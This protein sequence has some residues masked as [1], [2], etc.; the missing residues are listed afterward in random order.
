MLIDKATTTHKRFKI[1]ITIDDDS[2]CNIEHGSIQAKLILRAALLLVNE[3]NMLGGKSFKAMDRSLRDLTKIDAPFGG[4]TILVSG[5]WRQIL[6]VVKN[7]DHASMVN[8]TLKRTPMWTYMTKF[9][10]TANL[11]LQTCK[12]SSATLQRE[13]ADTFLDIGNGTAGPFVKL[14]DEICLPM[15]SNH[16]DLIQCIYGDIRNDPSKLTPE[17]LGKKALL[18]SLNDTVDDLNSEMVKM[19]PG[20]EQILTSTDD[21]IQDDEEGYT[22]P[23]EFIQTLTPKGL[24]PHELIL[25]QGTVVMVIRNLNEGA[26]I[27]NGTRMVVDKI[28]QFALKCTIITEGAF[29][30]TKVH[31]PRIKFNVTEDSTFDFKF[32]RIQFPVRIAFAMTIHKSEGQTLETVGLYLPEPVYGHGMLYTALTRAT[33]RKGIKVLLGTNQKPPDSPDGFYTANVVYRNVLM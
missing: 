22:V 19:L 9:K 2:F 7:G 16:H 26:G 30:G 20:E 11:R 13:W 3:G 17:V 12:K 10:L 6:S 32:S 33:T 5:D 23:V 25:K 14:H 24:P 31:L 28:E 21:V 4:K 18:T 8:E 27:Q 1:P 15:D 29:F